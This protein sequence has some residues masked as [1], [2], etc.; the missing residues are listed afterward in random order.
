MNGSL[1]CSEL[2]SNVKSN[3][4]DLKLALRQRYQQD[5]KYIDFTILTAKQGAHE[6]INDFLSRLFKLCQD[7]NVLETIIIS[8]AISGFKPRIRKSVIMSEPKTL[9][10]LVRVAKLAETTDEKCIFDTFEILLEEIK[11]LKTQISK[12]T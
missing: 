2:P 6:S 7:K 1:F 12:Q 9:S 10:E 8:V 11:S 5:S 3:I 4:D